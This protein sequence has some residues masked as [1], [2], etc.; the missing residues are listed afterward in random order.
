MKNQRDH[1]SS[2][3]LIRSATSQR[4]TQQYHEEWKNCLLCY[5]NIDWLKKEKERERER[6]YS[7]VEGVTDV[8]GGVVVLLPTVSLSLVSLTS[9]MLVI[10]L[11]ST[12]QLQRFRS[13]VQ[14]SA[15]TDASGGST[16]MNR[17]LTPFFSQGCSKTFQDGSVVTEE[18]HDYNDY[19]GL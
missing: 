9:P 10:D 4:V 15:L 3:L 1:R 8:D 6:N 2:L 16:A 5:S 14:S 13:K 18:S 7:V 12:L 11:E 19:L 17:M